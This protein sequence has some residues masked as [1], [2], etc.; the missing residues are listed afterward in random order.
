MN[1]RISADEQTSASR[2]VTIVE[3][4]IAFVFLNFKVDK[5]AEVMPKF[6]P[7]FYF[8]ISV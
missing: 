1:F 7:I 3:K 5:F 4:W 6:H 2:I 8:R